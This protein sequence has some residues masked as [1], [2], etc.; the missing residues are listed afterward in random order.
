[1]LT[2]RFKKLRHG[3]D[4]NIQSDVPVHSDW[5][6]F[7]QTQ[8]KSTLLRRCV[9]SVLGEKKSTSDSSSNELKKS[10]ELSSSASDDRVSNVNNSM[11]VDESSESKSSSSSSPSTS[12]S[13]LASLGGA[14]ADFIKTSQEVK[15][16]FDAEVEMWCDD[17]NVS[18]AVAEMTG[19]YPRTKIAFNQHN[20]DAFYYAQNDPWVILK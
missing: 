18:S 2:Y 5:D 11:A 8:R 12:T 9:D 1:L 3:A 6:L 13:V 19:N 4:L 15:R 17:E 14:T 20:Y 16:R 10:N 7:Q